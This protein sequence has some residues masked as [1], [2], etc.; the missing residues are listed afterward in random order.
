[1]SPSSIA[2]MHAGLGE[3][4]LALDALDEA[5]LSRDTRL[6]FLKDDP[7]LASLR[8]EPRFV[9]LMHKLKLDGFGPGLAPL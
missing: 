4:K 3:V 5:Y 7:R 1:V 6:V 8:Q 9:A 2:V